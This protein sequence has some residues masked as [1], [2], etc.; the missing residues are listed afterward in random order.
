MDGSVPS[1]YAPVMP[2]RRSL[3]VKD[4]RRQ[5]SRPPPTNTANRVNIQPASTEVISSLISSLSVISS[6]AAEHFNALPNLAFTRSTPSSPNSHQPEHP[7]V[8]RSRGYVYRSDPAS[9]IQAGFGVDYGA[10]DSPSDATGNYLLHP[11]DAAIA[12]VVRTSKHPPALLTLTA[13][14]RHSLRRRLRSN[15]GVSQVSMTRTFEEMGSVGTLDLDSRPRHYSASTASLESKGKRS[16]RR[17]R[18]LVFQTSQ[19]RICEQYRVRDRQ[20]IEEASESI[21]G[22]RF[23]DSGLGRASV[24]LPSSPLT[25]SAY[26]DEDAFCDSSQAPAR[27][28]SSKEISRLLGSDIAHDK[29]NITP[30]G[31]GGGR[32]IPMRDSSM[33]HRH[34]ENPTHRKR[35]SHPPEDKI[36]PERIESQGEDESASVAGPEE[37]AKLPE[38]EVDEVTKRIKELKELKKRRDCSPT[39]DTTEPP[40]TTDKPL[41]EVESVPT[42]ILRSPS[43][44]PSNSK[45][46]RAAQA[47]EFE[48]LDAAQGIT[49]SSPPMVQKHDGDSGSPISSTTIRI[50]IKQVPGSPTAT[51]HEAQSTPPQ[52]SNSR[53]IRMVRPP[54]ATGAEEN[55][56][57]F[58]KRFSQP[59]RVLEVEERPTSA[60][61]IDDAVEEYLSSPRLTRRILHPQTGRAIS[62]SDVGDPTGSVIFCCV[63]MGL[64]RYITAFYDEL[65][66]SLKLRLITPDRPGVGESE[67]YADGSDTPLSWPGKMKPW[68]LRLPKY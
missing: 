22:S 26:T 15:S 2:A 41:S 50:G 45:Q 31:I 42:P 66:A 43:R 38:E 48:P 64:T 46:S 23:I 10:Y 47:G 12:P 63:G 53:L 3:P 16:L 25:Y 61:S 55:K 68:S 58:S 29:V 57:T 56:R 60:D 9:P 34:A 35:K 4:S 17:P 30:R 49:A 33:R 32:V 65:A 24:S 62:F 7:G 1:S 44:D 54:G 67:V 37:V 21:W 19:E 52:R 20:A 5:R 27:A 11:Y 51:V 13:P 59:M 28:A 36:P 14:K 40:R 18:S 6:P 39:I 8:S